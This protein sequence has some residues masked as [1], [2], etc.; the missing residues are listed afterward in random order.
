[1]DKDSTSAA[2]VIHC[3]KH[4]NEVTGITCASCGTPIC[5]KCFVVTP[6]G[7]KCPGCG[8]N[9]NSTLFKVRPER[10]A[11]AGIVAVFSGCIAAIIGS[12]G[13]FILFFSLPFGYF[14]GNTILKSAGMKRGWKLEVTAAVG[15][16]IGAFAFKMLLGHTPVAALLTDPFFM[17]AVV[18]TSTGAVSKIRF[19]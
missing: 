16:A 7:M 3:A 2:N 14:V 13:L 1:M 11:L 9:V 12:L 17:A 8:K 4:P 15:I 18:I 10:L 6:V 5:P 19:L